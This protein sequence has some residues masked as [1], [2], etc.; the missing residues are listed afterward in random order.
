MTLRVERV[1]VVRG[2]STVCAGIDLVVA[3]GETVVVLGPSGSGKTSLLRAI[4]GLEPLAAGR[5]TFDGIDLARQP[6]HLRHFGV[7]FQDLALF[8][9]RDVGAN[10]GY[11]LRVRGIDGAER[12]DRV[13]VLLQ[14]MGLAGFARRSI[15]SLSGGERQRVALARTLASDPRLLL[16]DEPLGALDRRLRDR[17]VADLRALIGATGLPAIVVTHDQDEAFALADRVVLLRDGRIIQEGSPSVV[18]SAPRDEWVSDFVGNPPAVDARASDAG[19]ATPWGTIVGRWPA[20]GY[21]VVVPL[22]AVSFSPEGSWVARVT[23]VRP[24]R[25]GFVVEVD[26]TDRGSG[27][28]LLVRADDPPATG[29]EVRVAVRPDRVLAWP[30][31]SV[32]AAADPGAPGRR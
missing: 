28:P 16:F 22:R 8:P 15:N 25:G 6:P 20:G 11:A 24:E 5:V 31:S 18:W 26:R 7:V 12:D 21:R 3:P 27:V 9:H 10:V 23:C 4:A 17:L 2:G 13:Q 29:S 32:E 19:L 1:T 14:Q 30:V